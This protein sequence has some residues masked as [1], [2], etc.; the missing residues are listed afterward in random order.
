MISEIRAERL[1]LAQVSM[2]EAK[3]EQELKNELTGFT[4]S[5]RPRLKHIVERVTNSQK[6]R[7]IESKA[8]QL[9]KVQHQELQFAF[10]KQLMASADAEA[11]A[12]DSAAA[13]RQSI[14]R[15]PV[16]TKRPSDSVCDTNGGVLEIAADQQ[17]LVGSKASDR[18]EM[19]RA[20]ALEMAA[21][22]MPA[23][24]PLSKVNV[25][26]IP[27]TTSPTLSPTEEASPR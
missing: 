7:T 21:L 9:L 16:G 5:L 24:R 27:V 23:A 3:E 26:Q 2:K 17:D 20:Q 11:K 4:Q 10:A 19:A 12:K 18:R 1:A 6:E 15:S 14:L 22:G 8:F 25:D 13:R